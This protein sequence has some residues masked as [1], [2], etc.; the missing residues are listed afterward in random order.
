IA[1]VLLNSEWAISES[2]YD[3]PGRPPDEQAVRE[4]AR[5]IAALAAERQTDVDQMA[6]HPV[7]PSVAG[8][9]GNVGGLAFHRASNITIRPLNPL[10]PGR[11]YRGKLTTLAGMPEQG[12]SMVTVD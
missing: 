9:A 5:A 4:A 11:I 1:G 2:I 8:K 10:W 7:T 12:K 6:A 3:H